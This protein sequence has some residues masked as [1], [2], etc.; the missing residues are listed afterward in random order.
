MTVGAPQPIAPQPTA[1]MPTQPMINQPMSG[2]LPPPTFPISTRGQQRSK[3]PFILGGVGAGVILIIVAVIAFAESP[4]AP[5]LKS[6]CNLLSTQSLSD[7]S[8]DDNESLQSQVSTAID[9]ARAADPEAAAPFSGVDS[10]I[11]DILYWQRSA[12][13][14]LALWSV[15]NWSSALSN[16]LTATG[17]AETKSQELDTL[18]TEICSSYVG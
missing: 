15:W 1:P 18:V 7:N 11:E 6:A 16:A 12:N 5:Y 8:V 14:Q 2:Q 4:A 10:M 9:S 17:N 13:T 3:L